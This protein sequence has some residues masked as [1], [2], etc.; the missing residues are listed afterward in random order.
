MRWSMECLKNYGICCHQCLVC[1]LVLQHSMHI[2]AH[3]MEDVIKEMRDVNGAAL[4]LLNKKSAHSRAT[5]VFVVTLATFSRCRTCDWTMFCILRRNTHTI[6]HRLTNIWDLSTFLSGTLR[7]HSPC[8]EPDDEL[9]HKQWSIEGGVKKWNV[10]FISMWV[11]FF[12]FKNKLTGMRIDLW[13]FRWSTY[14]V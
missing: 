7:K 8:S 10:E 13:R 9:D 3:K 1:G 5:R 11:L 4:Y 2:D 14:H 12:N 6:K